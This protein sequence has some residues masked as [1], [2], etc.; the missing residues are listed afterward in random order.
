MIDD[1]V[2]AVGEKG[3]GTN[4][5][6]CALR[7]EARHLRDVLLG[8]RVLRWMIE[9][10]LERPEIGE[11]RE[12][13]ARLLRMSAD[14]VRF[15]IP[16][17]RAASAV[18]LV[19]TSVNDHAWAARLADYA[20][21]ETQEAGEGH[22]S[23]AFA[24]LADLGEGCDGALHPAAVEYGW[25]FVDRA[26][27]HPY[28]ILGAK[29]VLEELSV[30]VANVILSRA[31][32]LG[33]VPTSGEEASRFMHHHGDLDVEHARQGARD[34]RCLSSSE[35]RRQVLEGA[36]ITTG[37]YRQLAQHYLL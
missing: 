17:L 14:Y 12:A 29:S 37:I 35:Q 33:V 32:D 18:L 34:L 15:T 10:G 13:Y 6:A 11:A 1:Q 27:A 22:E 3:M 21:D 20:L 2:Q 25:Y 26:D 30:R 8:N 24:D 19:S 5:V 28:A 31:R 4:Y 23:W 16:A 9:G 7:V 36:Y